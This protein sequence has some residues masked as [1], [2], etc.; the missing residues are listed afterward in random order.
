[1]LAFMTVI[2]VT[3]IF[4]QWTPHSATPPIFSDGTANGKWGK[5][6]TTWE[7]YQGTYES[8]VIW[9]PELGDYRICTEP[10]AVNWPELTI[11]VYIELSSRV[12][13]NPLNYILHK[14]ETHLGN[15]NDN[16]TVTFG[17]WIK[18]NE[19]SCV[20]LLNSGD[21]DLFKL[22]KKYTQFNNHNLNSLGYTD[23]PIT[24]QCRWGNGTDVVESTAW[25]DI[26]NGGPIMISPIPP[27]DH[28]FQFR[29]SF[30]LPYHVDDGW[31]A[32]EGT[33]CPISQL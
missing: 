32:W 17:G 10:L 29:A 7:S 13:W 5:D 11:D 30:T 3:G 28:W 2:S 8:L 1:M 31:Y 27:C 22:T 16:R 24:W 23:I 14:F 9:D 15:T 19:K 25:T 20:Q 12:H 4:A 21:Y 33:A 26:P 18:S 6:C